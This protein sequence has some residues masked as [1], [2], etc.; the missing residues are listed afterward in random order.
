MRF[1]CTYTQKWKYRNIFLKLRNIWWNLLW[2]PG[3]KPRFY[4][5]GIKGISIFLKTIS[6]SMVTYMHNKYLLLRAEFHSAFMH[7]EDK[8][9]FIFK[10][11]NGGMWIV[12]V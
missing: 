9:S 8:L 2:H 6:V 11:I 5:H 3:V 10:I 12:V 1:S 4:C 7:N